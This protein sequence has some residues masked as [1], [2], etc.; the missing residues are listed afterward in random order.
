MKKMTLVGLFALTSTMLIAQNAS[1]IAQK[2]QWKDDQIITLTGKITHQH[3]DDDFT[4]S[5]GT[6]SIKVEIDSHLLNSV[7][8]EQS[9]KITGEVDKS[10]D[11]SVEIEVHR[12]EVAS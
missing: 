2:Q 3:D 10:D 7:N 6:G 9:L 4:F 8:R 5:D 1:T 11:G 12:V